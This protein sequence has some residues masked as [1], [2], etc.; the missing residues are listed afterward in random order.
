MYDESWNYM[1]HISYTNLK[2]ENYQACHSGDITSAP[3]G[4]SEFIDID[5]NS[6]L[7][8]GGRYVVMN[9]Y[10]YTRQKFSELNEC[11]T[12]WMMRERPESGE[13]F[14]AKTVKDKLDLRTDAVCS[15][16]LILDLKERKMIWAD[17]AIAHNN[18]SLFC[19]NIESNKV[20]VTLM[21]KAITSLNKT[22][23]YSLFSL[24][25]TARSEKIVKDPKEADIVFSTDEIGENSITPF[26]IEKIMGEFL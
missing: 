3:K 22:D 11:F 10:S 17:L 14:E 24:H 2:S 13:I 8:Y 15:I 6:V 23:L 25:A 4:A 5:I 20:G 9:V 7:K 19:N 26:D 1:E 21:G 16:P 12:G 18:D